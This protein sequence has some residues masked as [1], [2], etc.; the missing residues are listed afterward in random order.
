MKYKKLLGIILK[1]QN[2]KEADQILTVWTREAGK[3]RIL[4]RGLRKPASKLNYALPDLGLAELHFTGKNLPVLIGAKP[5]R[6]FPSLTE[7][8][9]KTIIGFYAAE[10]MLKMTA[11]EHPNAEAYD[12]L[13]G[14][15]AELNQADYSGRYQPL[16]ECFSLDLLECLGFKIPK[17]LDSSMLRQM[18]SD[19]I[20]E[21]H[22]TIN[23]FI[24]Y[25][26]ERPVWMIKY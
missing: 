8:L 6:N 14:F 12:L 23:K 10:L 17:N 7:D 11:D 19:Q 2:Y 20:E 15:L 5:I 3:V 16:L 4:A 26:I 24:E 13:A 25:I 22:S 9:Q 18:N 1:K 21:A